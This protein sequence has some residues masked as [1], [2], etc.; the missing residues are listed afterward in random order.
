MKSSADTYARMHAFAEQHRWL[1]RMCEDYRFSLNTG[2]GN[3]T[4]WLLLDT[5]RQFLQTHLEVEDELLNSP[6]RAARSRRRAADIR[7][8]AAL[9]GFESKFAQHGFSERDAHDLLIT[10]QGWLSG[11]IAR[12][13][14]EAMAAVPA[15]E[16]M[17][18][19][20]LA[21]D[22]SLAVSHP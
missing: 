15:N 6:C 13:D 3:R 1:D 17:S 5:I 9:D 14:I 10:V 8:F 22:P 11:H 2:H 16:M 7:I 20:L 12:V 18:A 19:V 4:Y 21:H